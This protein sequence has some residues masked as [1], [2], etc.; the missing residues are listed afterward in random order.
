MSKR[1]CPKC[2]ADITSGIFCQDCAEEKL[3]YKTPLIQVSEYSRTFHK[4]SWHAFK[5]LDE[6]IIKRVQEA[7]GKKIP[8]VIEPYEFTAQPK[9]KTTINV[10]VTIDEDELILPV[11]ISYR[12]CDYGQKEKTQY[13]EGIL[14]LRRPSDEAGQFIEQEMK[15]IAKKG[16]FIS[17]AVDVKNGVDLYFTDK[18]KM[19]LL[20]QKLHAKFGG[21]ISSNPQLFSHNRLSSKHIYRVNVLVE[22]PEF[23][24]NDVICFN[25]STTKTKDI[26]YVLIK[27]LGKLIQGINILTGKPVAFETRFTKDI[28]IIPKKET[29]IV[30]TH[31]ELQIL[32]PETF[33]A[34]V[35]V[36]RKELKNSYSIDDEVSIVETKKGLSIVE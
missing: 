25:S 21:R 9:E 33:Q 20:A 2:G 23:N 28:S 4:G 5:N 15:K 27:K 31:P 11:T 26:Q 24:I 36:N 13:F 29:K 19:Q 35:V 12:Q 30:A 18:N 17:K 8:V 6:I 3:D 14:Q 7:L 32:H 22:L 16:A 34:E 1:F 10:K